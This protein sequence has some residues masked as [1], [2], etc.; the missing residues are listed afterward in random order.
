MQ[1]GFNEYLT[2]YPLPRSDLFAFAKTWYA[3]EMPRPGCVWT[4]SLLIPKAQISYIATACLL[5][6]FQRPHPLSAENAAAM[7]IVFDDDSIGFRESGFDDRSLAAALVGSVLGQTRPVI[8]VVDTEDQIEAVMLQLWEGLW[9]AEKARFSFCTGALLPRSN[10]SGLLDLQAVPRATPTAQFRKSAGSAL[11]LDIL[12]P[13]KTEPWIEI[14]LDSAMYSNATFRA[15]LESAVGL[16]ASRFVIPNIMPIFSEWYAPNSS[17]RSVIE[18]VINAKDLDTSTR[19]RLIALALDRAGIES[20]TTLRDLIL[21]LC[22]VHNIDLTPFISLLEDQMRSIFEESRSEG[23]KLVLSLL[24]SE[25]TEVGEHIL[26]TAVVLLVPG[27]LGTFSDSHAH[28]LPTIVG[29]NS[30]LAFSPILWKRVGA[31]SG[32]VLTYLVASDLSDGDRTAVIDA[33]IASGL[34]ISVDGLIEFGGK[35]ATFRVLSAIADKQFQLSWSWRSHL[36][37][38][39]DI[40]LEWVENLT[41]LS[42]QHLELCSKLLSPSAMQARLTKVWKTGTANQNLLV[43]RVAAFGLTLAFWE[44]MAESSLLAECFQP[45][46]DAVASSRLESEEW[47]WLCEFAPSLSW[48]RDWDRCERLAAAVARLL[49]EQAASLETVFRIA[50]SRAAI[51]QIAVFLDDARATRPYLKSLRQ[52]AKSSS[53]GTREQREALLED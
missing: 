7:P 18:S 5:G 51:R 46:Y 20:E 40:V 23:I 34:D 53:N 36:S 26:R 29:A 2:G 52:K 45:T 48:Y 41:N 3:P 17:A 13:S 39:P 6:K 10:A 42:L 8:V 19:G 14:V 38:Q 4:H 49:E 25:L 27:D 35:I 15:W 30:Q 47:D 24:S 50:H 43:T 44:G 16:D 37:A 33:I 28:F 22:E 32:E 1:P 9:P 11:V 21:Y 31:R 12:T